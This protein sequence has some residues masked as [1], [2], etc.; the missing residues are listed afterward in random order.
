MIEGGSRSAPA[1]PSGCRR[2]AMR[3]EADE[4]LV[5]LTGGASLDGDIVDFRR[6]GDA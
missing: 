2:H 6:S 4:D 5:R 3:N 1:T